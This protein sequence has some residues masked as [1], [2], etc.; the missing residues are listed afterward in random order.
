MI[1]EVKHLQRGP[2]ACCIKE[3]IDELECSPFE[4]ILSEELKQNMMKEI[5]QYL[6]YVCKSIFS[7]FSYNGSPRRRERRKGQSLL[8]GYHASAI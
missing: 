2:R 8:K 7:V 1:A 4:I 6:R 5:C 3:R